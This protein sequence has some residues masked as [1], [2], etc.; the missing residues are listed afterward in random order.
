MLAPVVDLDT[1]NSA[2]HTAL[3]VAATH[4]FHTIA[5][6]LLEE[7][8]DYSLKAKDGLSMF[9]AA[10][11]GQ[12]QLLVKTLLQS[13]ASTPQ[14]VG[15]LHKSLRRGIWVRDPEMAEILKI[16][17]LSEEEEALLFAEED[18][19]EVEAAEAAAAS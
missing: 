16:T 10:V 7:G 17:K 9:D 12:H 13:E 19:A 15:S 8:A 11:L 18:A 4:G 6:F 14:F 5:K 2:G 1:Q 3:R